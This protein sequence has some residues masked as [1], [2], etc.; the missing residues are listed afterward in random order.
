MPRTRLTTYTDID[1]L[2]G[3]LLA[4]E[5]LATGCKT[6]PVSTGIV[7]K[8]R[9]LRREYAG[10]A[11]E[12]VDVAAQWMETYSFATDAGLFEHDLLRVKRRDPSRKN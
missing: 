8:V 11:Y 3:V 9:E 2:G 10:E 12:K 6:S 1:S 7:V 5:V 4:D